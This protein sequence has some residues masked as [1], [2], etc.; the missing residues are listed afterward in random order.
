M[1]G[2]PRTLESLCADHKA[3]E[4]DGQGDRSRLR[5]FHSQEFKVS[6]FQLCG[7]FPYGLLNLCL[8]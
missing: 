7:T 2:D 5:D 6:S 8:C 3:W 4:K 1:A